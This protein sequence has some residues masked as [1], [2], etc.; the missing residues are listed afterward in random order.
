VATL[1]AFR[2]ALRFAAGVDLDA[3]AFEKIVLG[4]AGKEEKPMAPEEKGFVALKRELLGITDRQRQDR[5]NALIDC[6]P[7]QLREAARNLLAAFDGGVTAIVTHP[8]AVEGDRR[9]LE[10]MQAS[11]LA[12]PD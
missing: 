11:S 2:E 9:R 10:A 3:D 4:A 6:T 8:K 7:G 1:D 12:L 5:R